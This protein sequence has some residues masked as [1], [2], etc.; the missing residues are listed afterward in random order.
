M[1]TVSPR[2]FHAAAT[3]HSNIYISGGTS[4]DS[5]GKTTILNELLALDLTAPWTTTSPPFTALP[6]MAAPLSGH[7]MTKV[8]KAAQLLVA[9]GESSAPIVSPITL[10]DTAGGGSWTAPPMSKNDTASFHRLHHASVTTGKDGALLHG[11]Y[12]SSPTNG[13]VVPSL[14]TLKDSNKFV[15]FSGSPVSLARNAPALA[16]HTM[17]LTTDGQA[18]ILGGVNSQGAVANMS[19]AYILDTQAADA[20]WKAMPLSGDAPEPRMSFSTVLVNATTMLVFGGTADSRSALSGPYYLDLPT[21]T[22]SSPAAEGVAPQ[23]WGHTATMAGNFMVVAFG[24]SSNGKP[25]ANNIALLDTHANAWTEQY[26]PVGMIDPE[27]QEGDKSRLSVGAVLGIAF[28]VTVILVGCTFHQLVR[29]RKRRT[30]NTLAREN[31]GDQTPRSAIKRQ[32]TSDSMGVFGRAATFLGIGATGSSSS[33]KRYSDMAMHSNPM[34]IGSRMAQLGYSPLSL[35]YP[36]TVVQH[37][38]GQVPVA[39]YIYPNQACVETEK[40]PEDGQETLIVYHMLTQAQQE[41]LK[42]SKQTTPSKNKMYQ[43]DL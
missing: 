12:L 6:P 13:A 18:V 38:S 14:V 27:E 43:L 2:W 35:G 25:E 7:T 4:Q 30:R 3:I 34:A 16:R 1:S 11:G 32:A 23:R 33:S 19:I 5:A 29:R 10:F 37:G 41:A 26:R 28:V 21:W 22:W 24:M 9:G 42:L 8:S 39:S 17:T 15:P 20:E 31:M 40:E 36:E